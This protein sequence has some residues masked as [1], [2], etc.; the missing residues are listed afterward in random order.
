LF[1][2][3]FETAG[4]YEFWLRCAAAN[5]NFFKIQDPIVAYYFSPTGLSTKPGGR[6]I[7]EAEIAKDRY[8]GIILE[9][10]P[11]LSDDALTVPNNAHTH[12]AEKYTIQ[13]LEFLKRI[14]AN[15]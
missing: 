10:L 4:D 13:Q 6:G 1:D 15:E 12:I 5:K 7:V 3:E 14:F 11:T 9:N 8:R 2:E